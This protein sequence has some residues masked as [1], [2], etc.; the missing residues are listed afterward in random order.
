VRARDSSESLGPALLRHGDRNPPRAQ[1]APR[2]PAGRT[3]AADEDSRSSFKRIRLLHAGLV[4]IVAIL[5][6]LV[7]LRTYI[8]ERIQIGSRP[9]EGLEPLTCGVLDAAFISL[10]IAQGS[11]AACPSGRGKREP[12]ASW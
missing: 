2:R 11:A 5:G 3:C 1:I 7:V 4:M 8:V 12:S 9:P 10:L 6:D